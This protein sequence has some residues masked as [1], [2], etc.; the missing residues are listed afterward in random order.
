MQKNTPERDYWQSVDNGAL[1][2]R[3]ERA[4]L[5]PYPITIEDL[6]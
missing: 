6:K 1:Q 3:R 5:H 4:P 2:K